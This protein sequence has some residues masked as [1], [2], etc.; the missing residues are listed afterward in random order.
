MP[1]KESMLRYA[2]KNGYWG[3]NFRYR[4]T[5]ESSGEFL[6]QPPEQ[7]VRDIIK[8]F[9]DECVD[10]WSK[11]RFSINAKKIVVVGASFGG[12]CALLCAQDER[13]E[14]VIALCPVIDWT[15]QSKTEPSD[16][17]LGVIREGYGGSFRFTNKNWEKMFAGEF[18][19]PKEAVNEIKASKVLVIYTQDDDVVPPGPTKK[20]VGDLG[21]RALCLK[22][23]G[24]LGASSVK[25]W[26]IRRAITRFL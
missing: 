14:K 19:Q 13:V 24:H 2:R 3:I 11:E 26:R 22:K 9:C 1:G 10:V 21:C 18:C 4:G 7:D 6:S 20:F 8:S 15:A 16:Y 12:A 25:R 23:G 5:W 17:L